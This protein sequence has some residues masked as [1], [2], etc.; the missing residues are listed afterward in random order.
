MN[1]KGVAQLVVVSMM[2]VFVVV[3]SFVIFSFATKTVGE[4]GQK[5]ADRANAKDVCREE[6]K[7]RI[8]G[9]SDAGG[10]YIINIEN[11]KQKTL[12]DFLI[13][14]E[15]GETVE[16]K[17]ANQVLGG[18]EDTNVPVEKPSFSPEIVKV[19][20]QVILEEE[21]E[22]ANRGWWLCSG[23]IALWNF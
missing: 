18:Y 8:G 21:I 16:I 13:R 9:V 3:L 11:L 10:N 15:L 17:K 6:V 23:E 12:S 5:S 4:G 1:K 22:T 20:P 14:Y 7:I 2:I 19:I